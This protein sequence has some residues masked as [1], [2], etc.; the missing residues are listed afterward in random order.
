MF[1]ELHCF[2]QLDPKDARERP[3][4]NMQGKGVDGML[5]EEVCGLWSLLRLEI[6]LQ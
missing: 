6:T 5:S 4:L 3:G 1:F 2:R